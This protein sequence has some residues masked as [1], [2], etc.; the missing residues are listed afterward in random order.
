MPII[1]PFVK[2]TTIECQPSNTAEQVLYSAVHIYDFE[3]KR[4][5]NIMKK[6]HK[7]KIDSKELYKKYPGFINEEDGKISIL[8]DYQFV[9]VIKTMT[10]ASINE[11][12][13]SLNY[14]HEQV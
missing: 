10:K 9:V 8:S 6:F 7:D 12:K 3:F 2:G 14:H 11:D 13:Y 5:Y 1:S 4:A